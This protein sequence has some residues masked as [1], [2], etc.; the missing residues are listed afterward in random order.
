MHLVSTPPAKLAKV[1]RKGEGIQAARYSAWARSAPPRI[2][3]AT[4]AGPIQLQETGCRG[5]LALLV[6]Q[7]WGPGGQGGQEDHSVMDRK[8][9]ERRGHGLADPMEDLSQLVEEGQGSRRSCRER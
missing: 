9:A 6:W 7:P 4:L 3:L 1:G 8:P 2:R 5:R